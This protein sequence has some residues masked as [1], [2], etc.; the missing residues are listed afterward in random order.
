MNKAP[1]AVEILSRDRPLL[2]DEIKKISEKWEKRTTKSG[3]IWPV[4]GTFDAVMCRDME[5]TINYEANKAVEK[6]KRE[7]LVLA[8][9]QNEGER[10]RK[11]ENSWR[12]VSLLLVLPGGLKSCATGRL[13]QSPS[14]N[15]LLYKE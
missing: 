10:W 5:V 8:L 4:G 13:H 14:T 1:T 6:S 11:K 2:K 12:N 7:K 9:F 3:A 15:H